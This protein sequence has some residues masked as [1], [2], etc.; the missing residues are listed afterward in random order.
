MKPPN[1]KPHLSEWSWQSRAA[2]RGMDSSVFFS[3][4]GERGARRRD[5]EERAQSICRTCPVL[6]ACAAFALRTS[7]THGV[8]GGLTESERQTGAPGR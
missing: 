2:C 6:R 1:V 5:R 4:M 3:P 8:W 7:Q